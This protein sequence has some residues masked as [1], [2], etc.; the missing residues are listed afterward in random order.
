[1]RMKARPFCS[2]ACS[3]SVQCCLGV[4][5][6]GRRPRVAFVV[7][8]YAPFSCLAAYWLLLRC[9]IFES[10]GAKAQCTMSENCA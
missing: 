2:C 7:K 4:T 8:Q 1:M 9:V 6:G 3:D 5:G 10:L